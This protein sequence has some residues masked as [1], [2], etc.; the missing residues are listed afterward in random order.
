MR[1]PA[2]FALQKKHPLPEL[3]LSDLVPSAIAINAITCHKLW[4][5]GRFISSPLVIKANRE[6]TSFLN[7][8]AAVS[9]AGSGSPASE[10]HSLYPLCFYFME[11]MFYRNPPDGRKACAP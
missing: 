9:G 4:H 3:N 6:H 8:Y 1:W 11:K 7:S 10:N 2:R 5:V